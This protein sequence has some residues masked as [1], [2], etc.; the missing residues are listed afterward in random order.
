MPFQHFTDHFNNSTMTPV[1]DQEH[2]RRDS[3]FDNEVTISDT[4]PQELPVDN[5]P[6]EEPAKELENP[7]IASLRSES[8]HSSSD[9]LLVNL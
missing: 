7:H 3:Y 1:E 8:F 9:N 4:S 6:A 2:E 5:S